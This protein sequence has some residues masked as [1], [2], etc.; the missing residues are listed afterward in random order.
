MKRWFKD[1]TPLPPDMLA[2][3]SMFFVLPLVAAVAGLALPLRIANVIAS[4]ENDGSMRTA[5]GFPGRLISRFTFRAAYG[6]RVAER[7]RRTRPILHMVSRSGPTRGEEFLLLVRV[8]A[9][10]T[11]R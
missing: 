8:P 4:D 1:W 6:T 3:L 7:E 5:P 10:P 11:F 2:L 9:A